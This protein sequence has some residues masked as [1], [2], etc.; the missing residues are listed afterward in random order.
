M[1]QDHYITPEML[2]RFDIPGPRYTSYPTA[3]RFTDT[4]NEEHYL[5]ALAA[6]RDGAI[7]GMPLSLY[8]HIPFCES[9]CYY[10]G[11][12]KIVTKHHERAIPYLQTL[13]KEIA[14]TA[15]Y[16]YAKQRVTQ[17]HFGGGSPTFLDDQQLIDLMAELRQTFDF[18]EKAE[19]SIEIDPR[20]VT[21]AR[22]QNLWDMGLNRISFGVQDFNPCVQEAVHRVQS[23]ESVFNLMQGA[24]EI[25]YEGINV[26]LIYGLPRQTLETF[27]D[28][29]DLIAELR[30]DRI[31]VYGYAH[32]PHLFKPQRRIHE[33]ELPN[34]ATRLALLSLSIEKLEKA[35]YQYIGMDHFALPDDSLSIAKRNGLMHRNFQ[36]YSTHADCDLIGLGVSSISKVGAVYSQSEKTIEDYTQKIEQGHLPVMR[37]VELTRDDLIRRAV[38]TAIM[39]QGEVDYETFNLAYMIDFKSYFSAELKQLER[40]VDEGLVLIQ[41][42]SILVTPL[43]W[44]FVRALAMVF[45]KY[46]QKPDSNVRFSKII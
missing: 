17:L 44:Y 39:C 23:T 13:K 28:T 1:T 40:Y 31:A 34:V 12:N 7:A 36:G 3:N 10:C 35:G 27:S 9:L 6:R 45:D 4:F 43:G 37:G 21:H 18:S 25:G 41:E 46:L 32:L 22:L 5:K 15:Q 14:L 2:S 20:T 33:E 26:D 29:L 30:P 11:C 24:R 8:I 42:E 16:L 38:I 19:C